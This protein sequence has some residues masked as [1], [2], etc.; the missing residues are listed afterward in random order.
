MSRGDRYCEMIG[1]SKSLTVNIRMF[2]RALGRR[3]P[4]KGGSLR[5]YHDE[6]L[7]EL[8]TAKRSK[9][10]LSALQVR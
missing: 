1:A 2:R 7:I 8:A 9:I 5:D 3:G 10:R 4:W 6:L